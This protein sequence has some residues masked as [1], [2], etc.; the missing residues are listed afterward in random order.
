VS[1][2]TQR[3]H[4]GLTLALALVASVSIAL[5]VFCECRPRP[6][7]LSSWDEARLAR[8]LEGMGY[9]VHVEP[10]DRATATGTP[11]HAGVYFAREAAPDWEEIVSRPR[12]SAASWHGVGVARRGAR[13]VPGTDP[14]ALEAGRFVIY[15]DGEDLDRI[16]GHLGLPR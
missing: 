12:G 9:Q 13:G 15:G 1:A 16:A 11:I 14:A 6:P 8:E 7:D 4:S 3:W 5:L 10:V 2:L